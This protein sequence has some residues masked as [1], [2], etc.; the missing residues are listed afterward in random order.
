MCMMEYGERAVVE[1]TEMPRNRDPKRRCGECGRPIA[2]GEQYEH[3]RGLFDG[4]WCSERTCLHCLA[5]RDW[6]SRECG[7]WV[8]GHV[9]EDLQEHRG[10]NVSQ[11]GLGRFI[12]GMRRKWKRFKGEG[13]MPVFVVGRR[14]GGGPFE[15]VTAYLSRMSAQNYVAVMRDR[16]LRDGFAL[17]WR[18]A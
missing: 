4:T 10:E 14:V 2:V 17:T 11:P 7:G 1:R 15:H 18:Q 8:Y 13:L 9:Y 16:F 5:A 6:L 3:M 12:V